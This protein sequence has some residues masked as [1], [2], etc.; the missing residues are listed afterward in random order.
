[1]DGA[2]YTCFKSRF[3]R[4]CVPPA[5][6]GMESLF[7]SVMRWSLVRAEEIADCAYASRSTSWMALSLSRGPIFGSRDAS[8][9]RVFAI[10][11]GIA[12]SLTLRSLSPNW[13]SVPDRL[14]EGGVASGSRPRGRLR[15]PTP[16][17]VR[18][19]M[20]ARAVPLN[21][22][23]DP[24]LFAPS[25]DARSVTSA[26]RHSQTCERLEAVRRMADRPRLPS[27]PGSTG[28]ATARRPWQGQLVRLWGDGGPA[29]EGWSRHRAATSQ[30]AQANGRQPGEGSTPV[31]G[32]VG[33]SLSAGDGL[34]A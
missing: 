6:R 34:W 31:S 16:T 12:A 1:M 26:L 10:S 32:R 18:A 20:R 27:W 9:A 8:P 19:C 4:A 21:T 25:R 23:S 2:H 7:A 14:Y 30:H 3:E 33:S 13:A 24:H 15:R 22:G 17:W 11:V 5:P 29:L 28:A